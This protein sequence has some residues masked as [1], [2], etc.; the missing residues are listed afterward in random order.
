[1]R[2]R[3]TVEFAGVPFHPLSPDLDMLKGDPEF[4]R[5]VV[6]PRF[7]TVAVLQRL[8]IPYLRDNYEELREVYRGADLVVA[9]RWTYAASIAAEQLGIKW[10]TVYLQPLGFFSRFDPPVLPGMPLQTRFG[11]AARWAHFLTLE[12]A[13]QRSL[14]LVEP[15]QR[16]REHAGLRRSARHPIFE[17][18]S[19]FG[20]MGWFSRLL[21]SWR[22]DWPHRTV[23]TG[24]PVYD[25]SAGYEVDEAVTRFMETG[26]QPVVFT[27]GA[28]AT[29]E[30]GNFFEESAAIAR[31]LGIRAVIAG[32][33]NTGVSP[34]KNICFSSYIP[35]SQLFPRASLIVHAGGIG[36]IALA[37]RAGRPMILVPFGFD[38]PDNAHR[39]ARL[40]VAQ[41]IP[42]DSYR[43]EIVAPVLSCMLRNRKIASKSV[44]ISKKLAGEDGAASACGFIETF[45]R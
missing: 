20:N 43:R 16:L 5:E 4:R 13:K 25:G 17:W 29:L 1:M 37:L 38:Q 27:L 22:P 15:I 35:Y 41:V 31:E 8:T 9:N 14:E 45:L 11:P 33:P 10:L 18:N 23:T 39:T 2:H 24:F 7:G 6:D 28:S 19:P 36:T 42:R 44:K 26:D 21:G 34:D 3:S 12:I 40:G 30:P 32:M